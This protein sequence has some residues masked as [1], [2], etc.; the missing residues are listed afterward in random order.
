MAA[1]SSRPT[2]YAFAYGAFAL[3]ALIWGFSYLLIKVG[4][5]DMNSNTVVLVRVASGTVTL[6]V[7]FA[8][9]RK[10]PAP[11]GI[12]K[13][14]PAFLMMALL[15]SVIPFILI[16]WGQNYVTTGLASILNATTPLFT[17]IFAYWVTPNERP[18][19]LNYGGVVLGFIGTGILL[20]PEIIGKPLRLSV[21]A[22]VAILLAAA[23]Y[24]AAA[25]GQRRFL[26]GADVQEASLWQ[27][28]L[29]TLIMIPIAL[30]TIGQFHFNPV[31]FG[32]VLLLG[33]L[34]SGFA[35]LIY[36]YLLNN[37]GGTRASTVTLVVPLTAV[38]WGALLLHESITVPVIAG[39]AV[40][41]SGIVLTSRR[42]KPGP[43]LTVRTEPA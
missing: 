3:L 21:L 32:A 36:Y 18:T 42:R 31:S 37:L 41:L 29:A 23:A 10:N 22:A 40:I 15:S 16:S 14:M 39:M 43:T 30:P 2:N 9:R 13:R 35:Y 26:A 34:G 8:V 38:L 20:A 25:L 19:A 11:A 28:L 4:D 33:S 24:A 27:L 12:R 1:A 17:A 7:V 6:L 5:G